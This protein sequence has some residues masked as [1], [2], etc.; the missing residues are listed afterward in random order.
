MKSNILSLL[1]FTAIFTYTTTAQA[2]VGIGTNSPGASA[3]LEVTSTSKGFLPPRVTLQGTD[4]A[5][6]GT[7]TIVSPATGLLVYNS[8]SA[9]SGATAVTPGFYY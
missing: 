6:K 3:Q 9:G 8:A 2:Q 4:D 7:P 1:V 5:T